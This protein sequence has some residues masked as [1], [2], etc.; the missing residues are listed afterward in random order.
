MLAT[1]RRD[2][3][4]QIIRSKGFASLPDLAE[5]LQVSE[6]TIRRDLAHLEEHG[7]ARRTHGGAFYAGPSPHLPH[8]QNRQEAQWG[9][10]K[11]IAKTAAGMISDGDTL[12]LDGGSTTYEL[13]RLL[14]GRPLQ[15]VTNS[16]PVANLLSAATDVE[17]I[18]IGGYVHSGSGAIHGPYADEML[19]TLRVRKTV[20]SAAGVDEDGLYNNNHM[21]A[22]TQSAMADSGEQ[23][24]LL[25]DSTKFGRRSL[26]RICDLDRI[27][28]VV[29]DDQLDSTWQSRVKQWDVDL[30]LAP[31][32]EQPIESPNT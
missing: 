5:A 29:V 7:G 10:K 31:L 16:M 4:L 6:S 26:A 28:C 14:A 9:Q 13:A 22:S 27:D 18:L 3:L 25:A 8:F 15:V 12:L 30:R 1:E 21:L 20:L 19:K 32:T 23:V 2:S 24:I 11:A 17:L